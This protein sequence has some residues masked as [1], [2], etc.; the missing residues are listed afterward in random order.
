MT[1][2]T[3]TDIAV[4]F[5]TTHARDFLD[6]V[7]GDCNIGRIGVCAIGNGPIRHA[8]FQWIYKA[9]EQAAAWDR[10]KPTGIYFRVTMLPAD[11]V[12]KG[13]G[14]AGDATAINFMWAD[15]DYGTEGHKPPSGGHPLPATEAE[16][17]RLIVHMPEPTLWVHS[18]GG[19][20]PLWRFKQPVY[21]T[22]ANR[23]KVADAADRWQQRIMRRANKLGFHYGNVGD[24]PRVLRL[25]GSINRKTNTERPC[26][27]IEV[28]GVLYE[29]S[30]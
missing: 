13:R 4:T 19:L 1:A 17:R 8:S 27:V 18:G 6:L 24:L 5:N 22:D 7:L 16:A 21:I 11:G 29:W 28:T 12:I 9:V 23:A 3:A 20:Y 14:T 26:R 15:L 2:T 10:L 25:P 30:I